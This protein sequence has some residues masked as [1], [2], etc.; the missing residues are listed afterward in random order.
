MAAITVHAT[1]TITGQSEELALLL[2]GTGTSITTVQE[3][4]E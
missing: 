1:W 3:V 4:D 2:S